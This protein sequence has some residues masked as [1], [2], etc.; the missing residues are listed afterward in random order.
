MTFSVITRLGGL[1]AMVGG[2]A[3]TMLGL[4]YVLQAR[5]ITLDFTAKALLK[6]HY[7]NPVATMLLLGVL[8][9]IAALHI[10]QRRYYGRWGALA[11]LAAF[12]GVAMVVAGNLVGELVPAMASVAITLL[13]VGVLAASLG[14]V[15]LGIATLIAGVLPKW[16]GIAVIV[17][18]PP[19]VG[20]VLVFST[21]LVMARIVPGEIGWAF[22]G[23]PWIVVS[24]AIVRAEA[25]KS[26]RPVRLR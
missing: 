11:S 16:C 12:A 5:G 4:L 23:I 25:Y 22:A 7:E 3:A 6:G 8:V 21:L 9:A 17:G 24:Y 2:L 13:I 1:V 14:I 10:I 15:G 20:V 18:S 26:A 19:G